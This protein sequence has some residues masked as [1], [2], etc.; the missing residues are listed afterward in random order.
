MADARLEFAI[1][2][3]EKAND[4]YAWLIAV[5][6]RYSRA[7][8]KQAAPAELAAIRNSLWARADVLRGQFRSR[9]ARLW[10][11][12]VIEQTMGPLFRDEFAAGDVSPA[13]M[14]EMMEAVKARTL[15]DQ[16]HREFR[17][18]P[19]LELQQQAMS[20]ERQLTY[21][22][23]DTEPAEVLSEIRLTSQL[24]LES[25]SGPSPQQDLLQQ[26]ERIYTDANAGFSGVQ[27]VRT[28]TEI[29]Q[30]LEPREAFIEYA[31][32]Y[33][34]LHPAFR[35]HAL[36]VTQ[37]DA[38]HIEC[39]LSLLPAGSFVGKLIADDKQPMDASPLGQAIVNARTDIQDGED[40]DADTS[41]ELLHDL[42]IAPLVERGLDF[43]SLD[44]LVIVPHRMLHSVPW[45]ALCTEDGR[46]L[47]Q[48]VAVTVAPSASIWHTLATRAPLQ[49]ESFLALANPQPMPNPKLPPLLQ[50]ESEVDE[51]GKG[52]AGLQTVV[53]K[54]TEA[55][56]DALRHQVAG[57]NIVH[58]ATHGE[59]PMQDALDFHSLLLA[60]S[61]ANDGR[62]RAE[63]LRAMDF[64]S[65]SLVVLSIC[66]GG[67]YRFGPG[68]EP[69]GLSPALLAAGA[70]H[71]LGTLWSIED[72]AGRQFVVKF[73]S[74]VLK[75]GPAEALRMAACEYLEKGWD[76]RL[77]AAFVAVGTGRP[78]AE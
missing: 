20:I 63:E 65:A 31:I 36:L 78:F 19:T 54:R 57:K 50:A 15:L 56:E 18:L 75:S 35:L 66:N 25:R 46:R 58:F 44:R 39:D 37:A 1:Q 6:A 17:E 42:L 23:P 45:A 68:D 41:L 62:V 8:Q 48:D 30:A 70:H 7:Q 55:T 61:D 49:L 33:H 64:H 24:P 29:Q 69:Y 11:G 53:L 43:K 26:V 14:L 2:L 21:F 28:L 10:A 77:W 40:P 13:R 72:W 76:L 34:P 3:A 27:P 47:V 9:G 60:P 52:L 12:Q 5:Q 71:L 4:P 22:A 59:F 38:F 32:P 74:N 67:I 16:M 73:Y 51:I